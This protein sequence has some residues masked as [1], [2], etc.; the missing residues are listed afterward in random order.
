MRYGEGYVF[1]DGDSWMEVLFCASGSMNMLKRGGEQFEPS[2]IPSCDVPFVF[3]ISSTVFKVTRPRVI[4]I[5]L[6]RLLGSLLRHSSISFIRFTASYAFRR[7]NTATCIRRVLVAWFANSNAE[8]IS[9]ESEMCFMGC[10]WGCYLLR[11]FQLFSGGERVDILV[12]T[13]VPE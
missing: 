11:L 1:F 3:V 13:K 8:L 2:T 12:Y 7:S 10:K 5:M 6:H 4:W 9:T